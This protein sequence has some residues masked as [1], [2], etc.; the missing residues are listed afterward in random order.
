MLF[1]P[2]FQR[3]Y[4]RHH[5]QIC[6]VTFYIFIFCVAGFMLHFI[7]SSAH[8]ILYRWTGD[9]VQCAFET[10]NGISAVPF[11][12]SGIEKKPTFISISLKI[13][14][15]PFFLRTRFLKRF[16]RLFFS[17]QKISI[18]NGL[19]YQSMDYG[20]LEILIL[21]AQNEK[22]FTVRNSHTKA[23][24]GFTEPNKSDGLLKMNFSKDIHIE[25]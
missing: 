20:D 11:S 9:F 19:C 24:S 5:R 10:A 6:C 18:I 13:Q 8:T 3:I 12:L 4:H 1:S 21:G 17:L 22:F 7:F 14:T 2:C 16:C 15:K 25:R 23:A